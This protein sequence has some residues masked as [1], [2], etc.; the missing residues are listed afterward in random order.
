MISYQ[1]LYD[2]PHVD[3]LIR[4]ALSEDIGG[5][6][7]TTLAVFP[8][9][10]NSSAKVVAKQDAVLCGSPVFKRTFELLDKSVEVISEAEEGE[11]VAAG[12]TVFTL[13]GSV[14]AILM[15]ERTALNFLSMMSGVSTVTAKYANAIRHTDTRVLDTRKTTPLLRLLE[16]Y[17]VGVGGGVNHRMG[18]Y[19]MALIKENHVDACG[20]LHAAVRAVRERWGN[21]LAVEVETRNLEE[22][23]EALE[24]GVDRIMLDNMDLDTLRQ[25]VAFLDGRVETEAS[26]GIS[27]ANIVAVA[28]TGVDYISIGRLT[29]SVEWV[30]YS[31]LVHEASVMAPDSAN[32]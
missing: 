30:D 1:E 19:D 25:A 23:R 24:S 6:D 29:H 7:V 8:Q 27:L 2:N 10:R 13:R 28:E 15:G 5:G 21:Q 11:T 18:L 14:G 17:A 20:S 9:E 31:L 22:V 12:R 26:G 4:N 16:K 32:G 3:E